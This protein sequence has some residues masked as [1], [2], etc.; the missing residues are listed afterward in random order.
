MSIS[1]L[2]AW[3]IATGEV[4]TL[5]TSP[6]IKTTAKTEK[7]IFKEGRKI[8]CDLQKK[9]FVP[10]GLSDVQVLCNYNVFSRRTLEFIKHPFQPIAIVL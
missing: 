2:L 1:L 10:G 9:Y 7:Q 4:H 8:V 3:S 6:F 5:N